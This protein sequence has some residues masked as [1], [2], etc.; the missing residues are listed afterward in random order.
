MVLSASACSLA[1]A[2]TPH[3]CPSRAN[4]QG[5]TRDVA[6]V[7]EGKETGAFW[8]AVGGKA[9]HFKGGATRRC[10]VLFTSHNAT[11]QVT[12]ERVFEFT[13][14]DLD[15]DRVCI[16][17][18]GAD[19][20]MWFGTRAKSVVKRLSMEATQKYAAG[21]GNRKVWVV[22]S[23]HETLEFAAHFHGWSFEHLDAAKQRCADVGRRTPVGDVIAE[24]KQEVYRYEELLGE[25]LP[26]GVDPRKLETYLSSDEFESVFG[27]KRAQYDQLP[28]WKRDNLKKSACLY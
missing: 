21:S 17:D 28:Q 5:D 15:D 20:Y 27:M 18:T 11:G 19:I 1:P 22:Q 3:F 8:D 23:G 7:P 12:V 9:E 2:F 10:P 13:Q 24:Y 14:D 16:L 6:V 4:A 25:T 26:V